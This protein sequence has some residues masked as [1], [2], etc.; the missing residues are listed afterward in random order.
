ME[1]SQTNSE[2]YAKGYQD[3]WTSVP[4]AGPP[5]PVMGFVSLQ[6]LIEGKSFYDSGFERGR[7]AA[8]SD[9]VG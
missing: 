3:G 9:K 1:S 2:A 5:P 8:A 4:E 6:F 7:T